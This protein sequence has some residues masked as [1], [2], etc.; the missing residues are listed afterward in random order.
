MNNNEKWL[1]IEEC[2]N[3]LD[4]LLQKNS[5]ICKTIGLSP[6]SPIVDYGDRCCDMLV[7]SLGTLVGDDVFISW[8]C[9]EN[10]FGRNGLEGGVGAEKMEKIDSVK[11]LRKLIEA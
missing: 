5:E 7:D 4:K 9:F 10:D 11:K 2:I 6:E 3:K 1:H 8:Y